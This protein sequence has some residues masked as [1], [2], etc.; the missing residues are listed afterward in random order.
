MNSSN[1]KSA[2]DI[3]EMFNEREFWKAVAIEKGVDKNAYKTLC[4][5]VDEM[6]FEVD[7]ENTG[8]LHG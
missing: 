2:P 5:N 3:D 1:T 4:K 7:P 8:Y 6:F